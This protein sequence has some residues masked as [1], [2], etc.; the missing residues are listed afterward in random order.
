[1]NITFDMET[2]SAINLK[3]CG[4]YV[5]AEDPSTD[6]LCIAVMRDEDM[7]GLWVHDKFKHMLADKTRVLSSEGLDKLMQEADTIEAHN[8]SFE[9]TMWTE[10]MHKRYGFKE[11]D[12]NKV[13]CSAAL[14]AS[15]ALPRS[16]SGACE[17]LALT[18]RRT[19]AGTTL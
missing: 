19:R 6:V 14:A 13:R 12:F 4:I 7:S 18:S 5:Y 17:A 9:T 15:Y 10:V 8:A 3:A 11:L 2:R 16:L 1:M